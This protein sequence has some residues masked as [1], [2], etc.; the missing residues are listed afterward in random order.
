VPQHR[1]LLDGGEVGAGVKQVSGVAA[2]QVVGGQCLEAGGGA[3]PGEDLADSFAAEQA[4]VSEVVGPVDGAEQR[5]RLSAPSGQPSRK[6]RGGGG[7]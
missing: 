6:V 7:G 2:A 1:W 4:P 3:A 5:A